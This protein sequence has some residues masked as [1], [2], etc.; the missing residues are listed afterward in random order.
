MQL[1]IG[2]ICSSVLVMLSQP[3]ATPRLDAQEAQVPRTRTL[4]GIDNPAFPY[5]QPEKVG[6]S[7]E[8][9]ERL[10]EEVVSWVAA[11]DLIGGELLI[12]KDGRAVFHEAYGWSDRERRIPVERNSIWSIKSMSKPL[13]ATA[14]LMLAEQGKLSLGDPVS[15]YVPG[16]AGH[17]STTIRH[18]LSHTSGYEEEVGDPFEIHE[19]FSDWV[20]DWAAATPTGTLGEFHYTDFGFAAAGYIVEAVSGLSIGAF[21]EE[22]I[23]M[24]LRLEDTSTD[25][26][27]DPSWRAR[28][29]PWYRWNDEAGAY[30]LRWS[31]DRPRWP[32]YPAAWGMFTT[33]MDYA[34]FMATWMNRGEWDGVRLLS[35]ATV[36]DALREQAR[37]GWGGYGYGWFVEDEP[38][39]A[40]MPSV[41]WHGGGD[42]TLAIALPAVDAMVIFLTYSRYGPHIGA[43]LD[44]WGMLEIFDHPGFGRVRAAEQALDTAALT[45]GERARY[46]GVYA[47]REEVPGW[48]ARVRQQDGVLELRITRPGGRAAATWAH[49]LPLGDDR[50]APGRYDDGRLGA[51]HPAWRIEFAMEGDRAAELRIVSRGDTLFS[52]RRAYP[53]RVRADA[54]V[55]RN[56]ASLAEITEKTLETEGVEAARERFQALLE[57]A[58]DSVRVIEAEFATLGYRLLGDE[59]RL[60]QAITV[61]EMAV[62]AFPEEPNA[63]DSLGDGYRAAGR[64]E[65][66]KRSYERAVE[67]GERQG[68]TDLRIYRFKLERVTRQLEQGRHG[69]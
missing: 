63:H 25:F 16:F 23:A 52:G 43:M 39:A 65:D 2:T 17:P 69:S 30:H 28:L 33:A 21:T 12:V 3:L 8:K 40:G 41:F 11:G 49:L 34:R 59:E 47:D 1:R 13:T 64:L 19:S 58:P 55:R 6:L 27:E 54:P 9:L 42:G 26:S 61:F 67:L 46:A 51:F 68:H 7:S 32:F 62:Q 60:P 50:F 29:N 20:E 56:R 36:G 24:P 15:R 38:R 57:A 53:D 18:L 4:P 14:V 31:A 48:I 22:R 10:G 37:T 5:A 35:E 44:V 45:R 66:A